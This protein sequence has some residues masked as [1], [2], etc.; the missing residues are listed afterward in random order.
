LVRSRTGPQNNEWD[1]S[2][3]DDDGYQTPGNNQAQNDQAADA[4]QEGERQ[5]GRQL[6]GREVQRVHEEISGR[7]GGR[8]TI[9]EA[10][11]TLFGG[12]E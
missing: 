9:I 3:A 12:S 1:G 8:Q 4:I 5:I 10:V 7:G 11:I 2:Y 6:T